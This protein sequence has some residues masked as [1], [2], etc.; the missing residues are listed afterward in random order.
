VSLNHF[1]L[2]EFSEKLHTSALTFR[3]IVRKQIWGWWKF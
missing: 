2:N 1:A 3:K